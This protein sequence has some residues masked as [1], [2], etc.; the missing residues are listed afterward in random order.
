MRVVASAG[1]FFDADPSFVS[2]LVFDLTEMFKVKHIIIVFEFQAFWI[3]FKNDSYYTFAYVV[4]SVMGK[5]N[6]LTDLIFF[7]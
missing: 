5:K 1:V 3:L 4:S 6:C 7:I 2:C